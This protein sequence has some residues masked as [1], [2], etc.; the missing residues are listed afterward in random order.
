MNHPNDRE[1]ESDYD[2]GAHDGRDSE[3]SYIPVIWD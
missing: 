3:D 2:S 1:F